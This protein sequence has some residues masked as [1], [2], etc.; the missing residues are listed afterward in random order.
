MGHGH[1]HAGHGH[2]HA[3]HGHSHGMGGPARHRRRLLAV[4]AIT[5]GVVVVQ[6]VAGVVSGSLALLADAGHMFSDAAGLAIALT[7]AWVAGLPATDQRTFG[8]Q[9]AEVL[10]A[11]A[12]ALVLM[13]VAVVIAIEAVQRLGGAGMHEVQTTTMLAG[14]VAGAVANLVGLLILHGAHRES[15]NVR[16]AYLEVLGDLLGSLAVIAA[17]IVILATGWVQADAAASLLIAAL[18]VPRAWSLLRDVVDVLLEATPKGVSIERIREHILSAPGVVDVHDIH[19]WTITSGVPVFSAH[20]VVEDDVLDAEGLDRVLD[21]LGSCLSEHFDT[22]HC[23]FQ[24]EPASH[25]DHEPE[26]HA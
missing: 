15:L 26:A 5:L 7:A 22:E 12:N 11:L 20:V 24:L 17:G 10:A 18:I 2:S 8:Y 9:R 21:R 13:V 23:T 4:L 1:S 25:R 14:A 3:G 19:A 16:G 6:I